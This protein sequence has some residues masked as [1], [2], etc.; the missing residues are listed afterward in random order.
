[1]IQKVVTIERKTVDFDSDRQDYDA[2]HYIVRGLSSTGEDSLTMVGLE[3]KI[4]HGVVP[5]PDFHHLQTFDRIGQKNLK[6]DYGA[7]PFESL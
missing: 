6:K 2:F 3:A 5:T 4:G 7:V 1:M